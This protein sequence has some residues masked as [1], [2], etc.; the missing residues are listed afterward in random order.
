[1]QAHFLDSPLAFGFVEALCR[2]SVQH[3]W[4]S[5]NKIKIT[6]NTARFNPVL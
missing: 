4:R 6:N 1:M 2:P 5:K 3:S